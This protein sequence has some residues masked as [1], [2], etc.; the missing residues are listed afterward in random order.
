M[1]LD[2]SVVRTSANLAMDIDIGHGPDY[3]AIL[4]WPVGR[5]PGLGEPVVTVVRSLDVP[6]LERLYCDL[7]N[8]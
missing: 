7:L 3:G 5:G 2:P 4:S 8:R 6:R 1:L